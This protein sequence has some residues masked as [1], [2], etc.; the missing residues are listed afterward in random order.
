MGIASAE[1]IG[2]RGLR[3]VEGAVDG[4]VVWTHDPKLT[5]APTFLTQEQVMALLA[6]IKTYKLLVVHATKG[7]PLPLD[8]AQRLE[9]LPHA[10]FLVVEGGHHVHMDAPEVLLPTLASFLTGGANEANPFWVNATVG[11]GRA[12]GWVDNE[13]K[14][15]L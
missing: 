8:F 2:S 13:S 5:G 9:L 1:A 6:N 14:S 12:R 7:M 3:A 11:V 15:R 4:A 10:R